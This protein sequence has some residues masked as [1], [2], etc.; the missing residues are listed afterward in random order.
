LLLKNRK[1]KIFSS[2]FTTETGP[3]LFLLRVKCVLRA[4][5]H[6]WAWAGKTEHPIGPLAP[7]R[8]I[9]AAQSHPTATRLYRS[10]KTD[11]GRIEP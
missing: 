10:I 8:S 7:V 2:L 4:R 9:V 1:E 3:R 6:F 5:Q 11:A